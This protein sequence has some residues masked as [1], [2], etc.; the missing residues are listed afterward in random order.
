MATESAHI[1]LKINGK[2]TFLEMVR[3][4]DVSNLARID[5]NASP[6][7]GGPAVAREITRAMFKTTKLKE[8]NF[9]SVLKVVHGG[10]DSSAST[11]GRGDSELATSPAPPSRRAALRRQG[12][13]LRITTL[14]LALITIV[15]TGMTTIVV[16]AQAKAHSTVVLNVP[17]EFTVGDRLLP[18]GTYSFEQLLDSAPG[19]N[20]V[21]IRGANGGTYQAAVTTTTQATAIP[22]MSRLVFKRYGN[23]FFLS[24]VWTKGKLVGLLLYPSRGEARLAEQQM[25]N[26]EVIVPAG[27]DHAVLAALTAHSSAHSSSGH[28]QFE[29]DG[30]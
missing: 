9:E 25:A 22:R 10:G 20:I 3:R 17:F 16:A 6:W 5:F 26:E 24:Q 1:A 21:A 19:L 2:I 29:P 27:A 11:L 12:A 14:S 15:F 4:G 30:Q 7:G 23:S 18:P 13:I 28:G 8:H